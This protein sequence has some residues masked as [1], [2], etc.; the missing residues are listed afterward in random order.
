[1]KLVFLV[2]VRCISYFSS[3]SSHLL[4]C[5]FSNLPFMFQFRSLISLYFLHFQQFKSLDLASLFPL[6]SIFLYIS[7]TYPSLLLCLWNPSDAMYS[8]QNNTHVL[9]TLILELFWFII[10]ILSWLAINLTLLSLT[11]MSTCKKKTQCVSGFFF[12]QLLPFDYEQL[13]YYINIRTY[14]D[15]FFFLHVHEEFTT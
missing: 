13:D 1:M 11:V 6:F 3:L 9:E 4:T 7:F 12:S 15:S 2:A 8:E 14:H 5:V 10:K